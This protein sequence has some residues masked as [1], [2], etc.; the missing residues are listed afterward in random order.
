MFS[1]RCA[2]AKWCGKWFETMTEAELSLLEVMMAMVGETA[3]AMWSEAVLVDTV[4]MPTPVLILVLLRL[5]RSWCR[6]ALCM[7]LIMGRCD[8]VCVV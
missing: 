8:S 7:V 2:S 4:V 5:G 1:S 6:W 3:G